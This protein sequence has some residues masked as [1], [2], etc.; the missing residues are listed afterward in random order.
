METEKKGD[1]QLS[2][3]MSVNSLQYAPPIDGSLVNTRQYKKYNFS[4]T[5]AV[6]G[7]QVNIKVNSG[8]DYVWGPTS[9]ILIEVKT[10]NDV[11][12]GVGS[13]FNLIREVEWSHRSGDQIDRVKNVNTLV[14]SLV[15]YE[16][17]TD[18]AAG[19]GQLYGQAEAKTA[20]KRMYVLPLSL[21]SGAFAQKTLI[22]ADLI[23]G[24][25]IRVQFETSVLAFVG[26]PGAV[27]ISG[28]SLLLD[29]F[30]L[31]DSAKKA[32]MAQSSN[33]RTQGL[34]FSFYSWFNVNKQYNTSA[35]DMDINLSAAQTLLLMGKARLVADLA[36][37]NDS[38]KSMN[39][40][41]TNWR[42]RLGQNTQPQHEV[43]D[44]AESYFLTQ[45]AFGVSR[46]NDL[47]APKHPNLTAVSLDTYKTSDGV[48]CVALEKNMVTSI[49]GS[50]T[51]NSRL[52]NIN[53][54]FIDGTAKQLDV[55]VKHLRVANVM[56]DN[57]VID[58]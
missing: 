45:N 16:E 7:S 17:G 19:Y 6:P 15:S 48:V 39:Y 46:C 33:V 20:T 3:L 42:V 24:S 1:N 8:S 49:S 12:Y 28:I 36:Q 38:M 54:D 37:G 4:N 47:H 41:Y 27:E 34:Q 35:F 53:G 5:T 55:W 13:A 31:F 14:H 43:R 58:K 52:L 25:D 30:D 56:R 10:E 9:A 23:A 50:P 2:M 18:Y 40:P 22:P 29:S 57:V 32:L 26:D 44:V 51:N 11:D 21:I